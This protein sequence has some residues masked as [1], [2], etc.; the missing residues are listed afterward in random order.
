MTVWELDP[1]RVNEER[2]RAFVLAQGGSREKARLE[3]IF[4]ATGPDREVVKGLEQLQNPDGGFPLGQ[5]AG[6]PSSIDTTCYILA[7]LREMPPLG[8]APMASRAVAFLRRHQQ[9]EGFWQESP[10]VAAMAPQWAQGDTASLAYLTAN[11]AYTILTMEPDH[12]DPITRGDLWLRR[13]LA[14]E[15]AGQTA[16][17]QTLALSWA[18]WYRLNGPGGREVSWGFHQ[19]SERS[20]AAPELAWWLA[21][22]LEVGAGGR[23]LLPLATGLSR[24]AAMQQ[25]DGSWPAE[26][27]F[28]LESTLTA[29]RVFQGFGVFRRG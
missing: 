22:A 7:Q 20:L 28:A 26:E 4:G 17:A 19:L 27:S 2:A 11:A 25:E 9:P 18:L 3:G 8:G 24:L 23:F 13:A 29:L 12:M 16:Y 5:Q 1:I 14:Q 21:L 15:K 10:P 6:N